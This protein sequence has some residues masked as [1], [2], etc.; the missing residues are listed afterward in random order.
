MRTSRAC[1][2]SSPTILT[3]NHHHHLQVWSGL[4][5]MQYLSE[6]VVQSVREHI[7]PKSKY[8]STMQGLSWSQVFNSP[9]PPYLSPLPVIF[10]VL[11]ACC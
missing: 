8:T 2:F 6:H 3:S 4:G 9:L 1:P 7:L 10:R 5:I 11:G